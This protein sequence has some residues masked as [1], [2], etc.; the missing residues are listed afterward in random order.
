MRR[1]NNLYVRCVMSIK[2]TIKEIENKDLSVMSNVEL[3]FYRDSLTKQRYNAE[4]IAKVK[5]TKYIFQAVYSICATAIAAIIAFGLLY[6]ILFKWQ[7]IIKLV[8]C[9]IPMVPSGLIYVWAK[10]NAEKLRAAC[11]CKIIEIERQYT[12]NNVN[13][14]N[15]SR[16]EVFTEFSGNNR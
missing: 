3:S 5:L 14:A 8:L 4:S 6:G 1:V 2:N 13:N 11:E 15:E 7:T 10:T 12:L 16:K 9:A